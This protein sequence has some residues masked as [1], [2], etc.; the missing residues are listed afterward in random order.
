MT[1]T[2]DILN[3]KAMNLLRELE[4]LNLIRMLTKE[5]EGSRKA[6]PARKKGSDYKG[7][8]PADVAEKMQEHVKQAREE[9]KNRI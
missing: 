7:I 5:G 1:I 3:E 9:W 4:A 6:E 2:I 8:L